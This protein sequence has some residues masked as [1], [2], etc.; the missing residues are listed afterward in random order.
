MV[1]LVNDGTAS[2]AEL[3]AGALQDHDRALLVGTPTFGKSLIMRGFPLADGSVILLVV[4]RLRTP[5]GRL[6]QRPYRDI[7]T[8]EYYRTAGMAR[9]TTGLPSCKTEGGRTVYGGRGLF[10]DVLLAADEPRPLWLSRL[11]ED[12][13]LTLWVGGFVSEHRAAL[14]TLESFESTPRLPADPIKDFRAFAKGRGVDLPETSEA[15]DWIR[16]A[17][18]VQMAWAAFGVEGLYRVAGRFDA[19]VKAAVAAFDRAESLLK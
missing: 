19:D 14:G 13:T 5:C 2:A 12:E 7:T 16:S 15:D 17:I 4:G 1:V 3:L 8:H 11:F 10:P 6:I 9:D 18:F